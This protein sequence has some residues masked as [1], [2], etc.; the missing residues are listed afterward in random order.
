M[1]SHQRRGPALFG[2]WSE[3]GPPHDVGHRC[4]FGIVGNGSVR[5]AGFQVWELRAEERALFSRLHRS[6]GHCVSTTSSESGVSLG[7]GRSGWVAEM[8][9]SRWRRVKGGDWSWAAGESK[10]A[11]PEDR[12]YCRPGESVREA[13]RPGTVSLLGTQKAACSLTH[14]L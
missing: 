4:S 14:R 5:R 1:T 7:M 6:A 12:L 11:K 13:Q 10:R 3:C 8:E 9:T 2:V